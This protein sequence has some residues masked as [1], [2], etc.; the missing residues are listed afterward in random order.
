MRK[1]LSLAL[2]V[3]L[4]WSLSPITARIDTVD[5]VSHFGT[6]QIAGPTKPG[7][8]IS[9]TWLAAEGNR[10][11]VV[12]EA[13]FNVQVIIKG[14]NP[15]FSFGLFGNHEFQI[16]EAG[17]IAVY[18]EKV[19]WLD[20]AAGKIMVRSN[21]A[22]GDFELEIVPKDNL[23]KPLLKY[24]N[25]LTVDQSRIYIANTGAGNVVVIDTAGKHISTIGS[26]GTGE[27]QL[28]KPTGVAIAA[29]KVFVTDPENERIS[30]FDLEGK[31]VS[32][33]GSGHPFAIA[34]IENRIFY[35]DPV[36]NKIF[37]VSTDGT[38][39]TSFGTPGGGPGQM[40]S[41]RGITILDGKIYVSSIYNNRVDFF[42]LDGKYI[43]IMG[44]PVE[45]GAGILG[46]P[47]G[48]V[49][50]GDNVIVCDQARNKIIT[51]KRLVIDPKTVYDYYVS[52]FG[53]FGSGEAQ[54]NNPT[55]ITLDAQNNIYIADTL[56]HCIKVFSLEG[57][58]K[59]TIGSEG[60]GNGKL[61]RPADVAVVSSVNK[62]FVTDTGNNLIQVFSLNGDF[63]NQFGGFGTSPGQLNHPM[64]IATDG[65]KLLV[66]DAVNCRVQEL[67]LEGKA[68][69]SYGHRG[70][71]K[72]TLFFPT[73]CAYDASGKI[74]VADTYN[75]RLVVYDNASKRSWIYGRTGGPK[76]C[77]FFSKSGEENEDMSD[78]DIEAAPGFFSFPGSIICDSD[79]VL[80]SDS[81]NSRIQKVPF[82]TVFTF[83]RI[84]GETFAP[85]WQVDDTVR[86]SIAP[87]AL[88]FG[89]MAVGS[90]AQKRIEIRNWTGGILQGNI[91]ISSDLPFIS[92]EP[93]NF[94]G[95]VV[96]LTIKVDTTSMAA[97][98]VVVGKIVVSTNK[99][100]KT[101][102]CRVLPSDGYG[103]SYD[104][105][106]NLYVEMEC[107]SP[108][109]LD[110]SALPQNGYDKT[111]SIR[112]VM[113]PRRCV[114]PPAK[115]PVN[116]VDCKG[117]EL[118]NVGVEFKPSTIRLRDS[119]KTTMVLTPRGNVVPGV[120]EIQLFLTSE[121]TVNKEV[122][123]TFILLVN[124][125]NDPVKD[126]A[127]PRTCLTENFTAVWCQY[128][129]YHREA[130]YRMFE[131]Y[132]QA[133]II[134]I[135]Y[136]IDAPQDNSGMTQDEH[137]NRRVF[138]TQDPGIPLTMFNG[139]ASFT[140]GDDPRVERQTP[141]PDKLPHRK[142]SGTTFSYYRFKARM[143]NE[144]FKTSPM[145]LFLEATVD[146]TIKEG[147]ATL[148]INT[149][150]DISGFKDLN[151]Y[152]T[153]V[154]NNVL[155]PA[156]NGEQEHSLT[157]MKMLHEKGNEPPTDRAHL[158]DPITLREGITKRKMHFALPNKNYDW[159]TILKHCFIVAWIQDNTKK[160]ILQ[161]TMVDLSQSIFSKYELTQVNG[162]QS[163]V[164]A[165]SRAM[166]KYNL[167]N[168]GNHSSQY[169][170]DLSNIFGQNWEYLL[171][172]NDVPQTADSTVILDPMEFC[173]IEF[174]VEIPPAAAEGAESYYKLEVTDIGSN[175]F[176]SKDLK[177]LVEPAKP[178]SFE[179]S[180]TTKVVEIEPS[181]DTSFTILIQPINEYNNPVTIELAK[182]SSKYIQAEFS[183]PNGIPPFECKATLKPI[184]NIDYF[185][186]GYQIKVIAIGSGLQG[187]KIEREIS[188]KALAKVL[189]MTVKPD[190]KIIT[191]CAINEICRQS[192][193]KINIGP[194]D[195][196]VKETRFDFVFDERYLE[197]T[198]ISLGSF[199]TRFGESPTF[200]SDIKPGRVV[201]RIRRERPVSPDLDE[202]TIVTI[203][204]KASGDKLE[205][206]SVSLRLENLVI[207]G[208]K[209]NKIIVR[210]KED[211]ISVRKNAQ[212]PKI[213]LKAPIEK[214]SPW[215]TDEESRR[216]L[217]EHLINYFDR[218]V[219]EP[220]ITV[221]GKIASTEGIDQVTMFASGKNIKL[222][223]DGS[224]EFTITLKEGYNNIVLIAQNFTGESEGI[225]VI[226]VLD[227]TPP[228]LALDKPDIFDIKEQLDYRLT[229]Y[230]QMIE[231]HGYTEEGATVTISGN[232]IDIKKDLLNID[233]SKTWFFS[234]RLTLIKGENNI[235]V[236]ACDD[237]GNC[238]V[239]NYFITY[240]PQATITKK[241]I[242]L[243]LEKT[244]MM[245][246]G[247]KFVLKTAPTSSSPPLPKELKSNTYM[248][249]AEVAK[250]LYSTVTWDAN[251]RKVT[252]IQRIPT[253]TSRTI[254]LWL[255]KNR[256]KVDGNEVYIDKSKRLYPV[257]IGGKTMLPLRFVAE[258]LGCDIV[259]E[260][261]ERKITLNFPN[262]TLLMNFY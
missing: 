23:F 215:P 124:P 186:D 13:N 160:E 8:F 206:E 93:R 113:P 166:F 52:E 208:T 114:V 163:G 150:G 21:K 1:V 230:E 24:A 134:P 6:I 32:K 130:Q 127:V 58:Y 172:V 227:T 241:L 43:G 77:M 106:M 255:L 260:A 217:E 198:N 68:I 91:E 216:R 185:E 140:E 189:D 261:K 122:K 200:S 108:A 242:E 135:A 142:M 207:L 50:S 224:F 71:G 51:F 156:S 90:T 219:T 177:L 28:L 31:F 79:S 175:T 226:V 195:I 94:V 147:D 235:D 100:N 44:S 193:I 144:R 181:F 112:Y 15:Q 85:N 133:E 170:V 161:S 107:G 210:T 69:R 190:R 56:N 257:S 254:E 40:N 88:D 36:A 179:L 149:V 111:V 96:P 65:K 214:A 99:G 3:I 120:Y 53:S 86:F 73:D 97:G 248:P 203:T 118:N 48:M 136:Y 74:F 70:R 171:M 234:T 143:E 180:T 64:G 211:S 148:T 82:D 236:K 153:L 141:I 26:L 188:V 131:E 16:T 197:V 11:Y 258:N 42:D 194:S 213:L 102:E 231:I 259:Y 75:D 246:N 78:S 139:L 137:H 237:M 47:T 67:S 201:V 22:E 63:L 204:M 146:P 176:T 252:I 19:Y 152:F 240:E 218:K 247:S 169:K 199:M 245:V 17:G 154:E 145:E 129:P 256:A 223:A 205:V 7:T 174:A 183:P 228:D 103:F 244:S 238:R 25:G 187:E 83:P 233:P 184:D 33:I 72:D 95:D 225:K 14:G 30:V 110:I 34:S 178:P 92:V 115:Q 66:A 46:R 5:A 39:I 41:P 250:E 196:Q 119:N 155:F 18:K 117:F 222:G 37:V 164:Q 104:P 167:T 84:D 125:C 121:L 20:R 101:I 151:A 126:K 89:A 61:N 4:I 132:G 239:F 116:L 57:K 229:V 38:P 35:T 81:F 9:P 173:M 59:K 27:G 138:Y 29:G 165:G 232:K 62:I 221:A 162:Q 202:N 12:D 45:K 98:Q 220:N 87:S 212:P 10:I 123:L 209:G 105:E 251:E 76:R 80:I 49:I 55:G 253:R 2:T 182:D 157:V 243:W 128:C 191:S 54:L 158:G 168:L 60:R 192:D 109:S 262:K 159:K 249:L